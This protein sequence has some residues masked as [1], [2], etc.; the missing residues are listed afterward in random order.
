MS[1]D[2]SR[3]LFHETF[4]NTLWPP[5]MQPE[6]GH[7]EEGFM[8]LKVTRSTVAGETLIIDDTQLETFQDPVEAE[9]IALKRKVEV[10]NP[11]LEALKKR[12]FVVHNV[13][14]S[15]A[16][17]L[18]DTLPDEDLPEVVHQDFLEVLDSPEEEEKG[19]NE[20]VKKTEE[21]L[22]EESQ[23]DAQPRWSSEDIGN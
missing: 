5:S 11:W 9:R 13:S 16:S 23:Q 12:G 22:L 10:D 19:N 20:K 8:D 4:E 15:Q 21:K 3:T 7:E 2:G 17:S 14:D 6:E 18:A 1:K